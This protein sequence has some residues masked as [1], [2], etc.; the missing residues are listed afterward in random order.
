MWRGRPW[1][2]G[3]EAEPASAVVLPNK[4]PGCQHRLHCIF[5][6]MFGSA[7]RRID[8]TTP[9]FVPDEVTQGA[10]IAAAR[11]GVRVRILVPHKSDIA[12]VRWIA[13][14]LYTRLLRH[15]VPVFGYRPR[16]LHAKTVTVDGDWATVGPANLDYR[17]LFLNHELNLCARDPDLAA[18]LEAQFDADL[19]EAEETSAAAPLPGT[20]MDRMLAPVAW[21]A[22]RWL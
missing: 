2:P 8:L 16:L 1:S 9:Y 4:S 19:T 7:R 13:R 14:R 3:P 15:G 5:A 12:P 11:R 10:L 22:R 6:A 18:M 21:G 20:T 17:S